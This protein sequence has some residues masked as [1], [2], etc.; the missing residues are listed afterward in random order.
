MRCRSRP[1]W[2]LAAVVAVAVG[3]PGWARA[4]DEG[5]ATG[6]TAPATAAPPATAPAKTIPAT[7]APATT[8][9]A[10]TPPA[11][12]AT[13]TTPPEKAP[14]VALPEVVVPVPEAPW[15]QSPQERDPSGSLTVVEASEHRG[16]AKNT[17]Q[18]LAP[19][20]GAVV[21]ETGG[22]G[23]AATLS[24]RGA[25][26][27]ALLVLLDGVPLAGP[28]SNVDLSRVPAALVERLEVLRGAQ[29]A[30][31]GAGAMGGVVNVVTRRTSQA[32]RVYAEASQGSFTT[33]TLSAGASGALLGGEAL[34]SLHG[35]RSA[36]DFGF[37]FNDTPTLAGSAATWRTRA[38]NDAL[39]GG[40]LLR[41]RTTLKGTAL[42]ATLEGLVERR[43][44]AG[45]AQNPTDD[46]RQA[47]ERLSAT[48]R[49]STRFE[50]VGTLSAFGYGRMDHLALSGT[51]FGALGGQRVMSAGAEL[52]YRQLFRGRHGLSAL[53]SGGGEW[54]ITSGSSARPTWGKAAV[55]LAAEE[56]FW[57]GA[58]AVNAAARLEVLGPFVGVSPKVGAVALLPRGF[59]LRANVGQ[60]FRPPSFLELYVTQGSLSPNPNLRPERGLTADLAVA[61]RAPQG[62]GFAQLGAFGGL[63]ED[64]ISYEYYPPG[65][66]R[67]YNFQGAR[68]GGLEA[69]ATAAPKPWLSATVGYTLLFAQNMKDDERYYLKA[70]PYRPRHKLHGTLSVG[71]K[72]L[73]ARGEVL[74]QAQQFVNRTET[75]DIPARAFVNLG[76]TSEPFQTLGLKFGVELKNALDVQSMDTDGY[77]L[78]PRAVFATVAMAWDA[79]K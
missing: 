27:N 79:A 48:V 10:T 49:S 47:S 68:V 21:R 40:G 17:A 43:G 71:P 72:Q 22:F 7:T 23:Q 12:T 20:P 26:P 15:A 54:L 25:A 1:M 42:D 11:T 36:G 74:F 32:A 3:A 44:L 51:G 45:T 46:A 56:L 4:H 8:T 66:A 73:R 69:E 29:G 67:P 9:P 76:L 37:A 18:L 55:M 28:G 16:E 13:A 39:Q 33:T 64:L 24:L 31:Y 50:A 6:P 41:Y 5:P 60:G 14:A 61:W 75:V 53:I 62:Q 78:P 70:L 38:N 52:H 58:L 59:E 34:L 19:V 57:G 63:Y 65:L 30:L 77:P 2:L 35:G